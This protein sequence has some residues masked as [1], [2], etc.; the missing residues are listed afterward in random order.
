[1]PTMNS[2]KLMTLLARLEDSGRGEE[3]SADFVSLNEDSAM[4][5]RGGNIPPGNVSCGNSNAA[6]TGNVGCAGNHACSNNG[7][8]SANAGCGGNEGCWANQVC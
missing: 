2:N 8:C 4:R 7:G 3:K 1:M 5:L 6:C